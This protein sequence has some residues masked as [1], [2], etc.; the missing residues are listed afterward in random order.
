MQLTRYS[1]LNSHSAKASCL[2]SHES[3][4]AVRIGSLLDKAMR[5]GEAKA[6]YALILLLECLRLSSILD[7]VQSSQAHLTILKV[8]TNVQFIRGTKFLP[9]VVR[10]RQHCTPVKQNLDHL[11]IVCVGRK[12]KWRNVWGEI[13][14]VHVHCFPTLRFYT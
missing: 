13:C 10:T 9:L 11:V 14:N 3:S 12:Y 6:L 8:M 4:K 7:T 5:D 2:S 1:L